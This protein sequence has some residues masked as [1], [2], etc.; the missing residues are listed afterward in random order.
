M[1]SV[2]M[3]SVIMLSVVMLSVVMLSVV[4]L[5][6]ILLSVVM[7]SVVIVMLNGEVPVLLCPHENKTNIIKS[8][9]PHSPTQEEV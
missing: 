6:V 9:A 2:V 7:L 8:Y 3:L 4:M 5:C 1:P